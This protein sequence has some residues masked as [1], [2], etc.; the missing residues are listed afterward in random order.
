MYYSDE[1]IQI[2]RKRGIVQARDLEELGISRNHLYDLCKKGHLKRL[3]RGLYTLDGAPMTEHLSLVETAKR[4]PSAVVCLLSAL[5]FHE[6]GTQMPKDVWIAIPRGSWRPR[7]KSPPINVTFLSN[8]AYCHGIQ[9][10]NVSGV[11]VNIYSPAKTVADCF[12]FR[13]KVGIDV[14]IESLKEALSS[15]KTTVDALIDAA[16]INRV[17]PIMQPYLEAIV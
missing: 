14:A 16:R 8:D 13:N 15:R 17:S 3:A 1:I 7:F 6:I 4:V 10:H 11:N 2:A 12:K 9:K 5:R